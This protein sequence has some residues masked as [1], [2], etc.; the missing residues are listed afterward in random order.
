MWWYLFCGGEFS[1]IVFFTQLQIKTKIRIWFCRVIYS[2]VWLK[3]CSHRVR[4]WVQI[5]TLDFWRRTLK[6]VRVIGICLCV[7]IPVGC[8]YCQIPKTVLSEKMSQVWTGFKI[9]GKTHLFR[10]SLK[11]KKLLD[12]S[13]QQP[14]KLSPA[15]FLLAWKKA[16]YR[17]LCQWPSWARNIFLLARSKNWP[18]A[19]G[20]VLKFTL[21]FW[22][23]SV[24][25]C[26]R[27]RGGDYVLNPQDWTNI[28][29]HVPGIPHRAYVK[30]TI[31]TAVVILEP[32]QDGRKCFQSENS[33]SSFPSSRLNW[34]QFDGARFFFRRGNWFS[35][36][37]HSERQASS[38]SLPIFLPNRTHLVCSSVESCDFH[39]ANAAFCPCVGYRPT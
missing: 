4:I 36:L 34:S 26:K 1:D 35:C 12:Q 24:D 2:F 7:N 9:S 20:P 39:V 10:R 29:V 15:D 30:T 31:I 18:L 5:W 17:E 6:L 38:C 25:Q 13:G 22:S 23:K 14:L 3:A 37:F 33:L 32:I 16:N 21:P 11:Q 8:K 28:W 27:T 19:S